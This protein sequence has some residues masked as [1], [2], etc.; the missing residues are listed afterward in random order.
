MLL[1]LWSVV[2]QQQ[3]TNTK[4]EYLNQ[5]WL[6]SK[7]VVFSLIK[8]RRKPSGSDKFEPHVI[9]SLEQMCRTMGHVLGLKWL[10]GW[11]TQ[12]QVIALKNKRWPSTEKTQ[13]YRTSGKICFT[14]FWFRFSVTGKTRH[15]TSNDSYKA[16]S[17][18]ESR[19]IFNDFSKLCLILFW[20]NNVIISQSTMP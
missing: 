17:S 11:L 10:A 9:P 6:T 15:P 14:P 1:N 16:H 8:E 2:K 5:G 7:L 12:K 13:R 20:K 18:W 19:L 3:K 4:S